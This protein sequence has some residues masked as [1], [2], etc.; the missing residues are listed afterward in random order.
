MSTTVMAER[1]KTKVPPSLRSQFKERVNKP[2]AVNKYREGQK[3]ASTRSVNILKDKDFEKSRKVL[4]AKRK[5][6][7][8]EHGKGNKPQA[9]TA[10]KD[11][12]EDALFEIGEFGYSN[13]VSLQRTV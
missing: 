13:P 3:R 7:I 11:K 2:E 12:D 6:L 5:S 4:A 9:T 10:L 8:H 1:Y